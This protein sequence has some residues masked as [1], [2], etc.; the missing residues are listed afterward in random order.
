MRLKQELT[1]QTNIAAG[2]TKMKETNAF[3][4]FKE[5]LTF[6]LKKVDF[7]TVPPD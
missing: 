7:K 3:V 5:I 6:I 4:R 1:R 2:F